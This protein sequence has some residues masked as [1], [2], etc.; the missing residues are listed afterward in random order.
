MGGFNNGGMFGNGLGNFQQPNIGLGS[1]GNNGF[2]N[3]GL[4]NRG[5]SNT[6]ANNIG[7]RI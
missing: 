1:F 7:F 6:F 4:F 5:L 3:G 2:N